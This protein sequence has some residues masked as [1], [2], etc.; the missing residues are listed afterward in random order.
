MGRADR[1]RAPDGLGPGGRG[2][3][4]LDNYRTSTDGENVSGLAEAVS[5]LRARPV[6]PSAER[7]LL[8]SAR[9]GAAAMPLPTASPETWSTV[10]ALAEAH[11]TLAG[12]ALRFADADGLPSGVRTRFARIRDEARSLDRLHVAVLADLLQSFASRRLPVMVLKGARIAE[13]LYGD[14]AAR[15]GKDI[16]LLVRRSDLEEAGDLLRGRGF[17]CHD[18]AYYDAHHFHHTWIH[19]SRALAERVELHWDVTLPVS[20]VRF[21][22]DSWWQEPAVVRLR[23]GDVS[24]PP[25]A[26]EFAYV[27]YHATCRGTPRLRDL[28]D[29]AGLWGKASP[30]ARAAM[31]ESAEQAGALGYVATALGLA[32]AFWGLE[33]YAGEAHTARPFLVRHI[34]SPR[35]IAGC[36]NQTWWAIEELGAWSLQS[37][38]KADPRQLLAMALQDRHRSPWTRGRSRPPRWKIAG[39]MLG[40]VGVVALAGA[41]GRF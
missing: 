28:G 18:R 34:Y 37:P 26:D 17:V 19:Q 3:E 31:I 27:A 23:A 24:V 29:I 9:P 8:E 2:P 11:G 36:P 5:F 14:P 25:P 4:R 7:L 41:L 22:I 35:R 32:N 40:A 16:D 33:G 10:I 39:A 1:R 6:D 15:I 13:E 20:S 38:G 30:I 12:C 21:P